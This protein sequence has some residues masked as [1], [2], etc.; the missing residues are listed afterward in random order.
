MCIRDS[1]HAPMLPACSAKTLKIMA[2]STT[3]LCY[4]SACRGGVLAGMAAPLSAGR[5]NKGFTTAADTK[6]RTQSMRKDQTSAELSSLRED[7]A[8]LGRLDAAR[9]GAGP[10]EDESRRTLVDRCIVLPTTASAWVWPGGFACLEGG[11]LE[12]G[13]FLRAV[14]FVF[15]VVVGK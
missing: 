11:G 15:A 5:V 3:H 8:A 12:F 2:M 9:V 4:L 6:K 13:L 7:M 14:F 1:H 10:R